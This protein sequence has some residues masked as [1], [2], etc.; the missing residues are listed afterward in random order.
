M[1]KYCLIGRRSMVEDS[2]IGSSKA[3]A[4]ISESSHSSEVLMRMPFITSVPL[5]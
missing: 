4:Y 3:L 2:D 1:Q 5:V